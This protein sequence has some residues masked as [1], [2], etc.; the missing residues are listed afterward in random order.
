MYVAAVPY[1]ERHFR[2]STT[3]AIA[4][5]SLYAYGLGI[6]ALFGTAAC[7][8]YGRSIVYQVS[9][10]IALSFTIVGG[11]AKNFTTLAA[12]R[13]FAGL[14]SGPCLTVGAGTLNDLWDLSLEKTGTTF[15]VLFVM[16]IIWA[17]Q[18]TPMASASLMNYHGWQWVFW[19]SAILVGINM[20]LAFLIPESYHPAIVRKRSKRLGLPVPSRGDSVKVFL[21][22]VGRPLHMIIV[23][24]IVFPTGMVLA[25]TQSIVFCYYIA[26]A[27]LF[28]EVYGFS[29]Y[30][31]GMAFGALAV[32]SVIAVPVI[33]LFD[34]L[35]YQKAREEAIRLGTTVAPENRLYPAMLSSFITPISLFW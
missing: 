5:T 23:E 3:L 27:L 9:L 10:P 32:G 4:P 34:K 31:S 13:T 8:I 14:A 21:T 26:Y 25:V 15:A 1:V 35:T 30:Q 33:G 19:A 18:A 20:V 24:P 7:E 22:A 11:T 29:Q 28:E 12:A 2:I 17:T 6:G 16:S